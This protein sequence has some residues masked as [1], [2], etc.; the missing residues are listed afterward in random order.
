ME[1]VDEAPRPVE[2]RSEVL[3]LYYRLARGAPVALADWAALSL[4]EQAELR[5]RLHLVGLFVLEP[6]GATWAPVRATPDPRD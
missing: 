6:P 5:E 3:R 2:N 4:A 1:T